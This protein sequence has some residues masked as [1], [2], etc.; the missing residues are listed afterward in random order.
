MTEGQVKKEVSKEKSGYTTVPA[1]KKEHVEKFI[2]TLIKISRKFRYGVSERRGVEYVEFADRFGLNIQ[3]S[4]L[5]RLFYGMLTSELKCI[6]ELVRFICVKNRHDE[7]PHSY[8]LLHPNLIAEMMEAYMPL[9]FRKEE[10]NIYVE[11]FPELVTRICKDVKGYSI[12]AL[13]KLEDDEPK[14]YG[15]TGSRGRE[16]KNFLGKYHTAEFITI[17]EEGPNHLISHK[18]LQELKTVF[19]ESLKQCLDYRYTDICSKTSKTIAMWIGHELPRH[20]VIRYFVTMVDER[21]ANLLKGNQ[22]LLEYSS[23]VVGDLDTFLFCSSQINEWLR[24]HPKILPHRGDGR[25]QLRIG[26]ITEHIFETILKYVDVVTLERMYNKTDA[27]MEDALTR[28]QNI[29]DP[30]LQHNLGPTCASTL[31]IPFTTDCTDTMQPAVAP[32]TTTK[33]AEQTVEELVKKY[34]NVYEN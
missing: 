15:S 5:D 6:V 29:N 13:R 10:M 3:G 21:S 8:E 23:I 12:F 22:R 4:A 2:S 20:D 34:T 1:E 27:D 14:N 9:L 31:E 7:I 16:I 19:R 28:L 25:E 17:P 33:T 24:L 26:N 30:P 11:A 18:Y 32:Q